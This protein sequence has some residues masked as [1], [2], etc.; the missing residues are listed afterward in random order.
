MTQVQ[1]GVYP[2][3]ICLFSAS[4]YSKLFPNRKSSSTL[5]LPGC[6]FQIRPYRKFLRAGFFTL[7]AH[8][9]VATL[10]MPRRQIKIICIM[11]GRI[12]LH[13]HPII[14]KGKIL[15]NCNVFRAS[16]S[17]VPASG[18]GNLCPR[19]DDFGSLPDDFIFCFIQRFKFCKYPR[20]VL[21]LRHMSVSL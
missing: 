14:V 2:L 9:T 20:I 4:Y 6:L 15:G 3:R 13:L 21:Y 11:A 18:T 1:K 5:K 17:T 7:A 12:A 8:D 16:M 19:I 10:S